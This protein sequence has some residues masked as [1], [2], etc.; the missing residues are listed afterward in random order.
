MTGRSAWC[1]GHQGFGPRTFRAAWLPVEFDVSLFGHGC[2][3]SPA[4]GRC[5]D[6]LRH[7]VSVPRPALAWARRL[8]QEWAPLRKALLAPQLAMAW[9]QSPEP[10]LAPR[11]ALGSLLRWGPVSAPRSLA[12]SPLR[13]VPRLALALLP[14]AERVPRS[15]LVQLPRPGRQLV[16]SAGEL[17]F[18]WGPGWA[19]WSPATGV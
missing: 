15:A 5:R 18:P 19:L 11:P 9:V 8:V 3:L 4:C 12:E 10:P 14:A 17:A 2:G 1:G 13:R 6:H 16:R 7:R